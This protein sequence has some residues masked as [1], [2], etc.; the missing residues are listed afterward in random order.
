MDKQEVI[1]TLQN[2]I[3]GWERKV[4]DEDSYY[5]DCNERVTD[6]IQNL[7][8]S[9]EDLKEEDFPEDM[10][11]MYA[12]LGIDLTTPKRKYEIVLN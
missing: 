10:V 5:Y 3:Y 6:I 2:R 7:K 1:N 12:D 4:L 8:D 9:I 11:I